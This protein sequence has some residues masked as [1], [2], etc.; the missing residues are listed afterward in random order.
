MRTLSRAANKTQPLSVPPEF[1]WLQH[2]NTDEQANFFS[3]LLA[4][5]LNAIKSNDWLPVA[6]WVEEWKAT[7]NVYADSQVA[8]AVKEGQEELARSESVDWETLR[9]EFSL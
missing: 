3:G 5:V 2:L 6:E 4:R 7:A 9:K 8:R 1:T